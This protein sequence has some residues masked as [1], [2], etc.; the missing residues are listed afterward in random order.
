MFIFDQE[1]TRGL[2]IRSTMKGGQEGKEKGSNRR[3]D[4]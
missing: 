3:G 2:V 1:M 4:K